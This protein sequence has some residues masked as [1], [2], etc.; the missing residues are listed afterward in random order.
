MKQ[1]TAWLLSLVL[2]FTMLCP[3][4]AEEEDEEGEEVS[5]ELLQESMELDAIDDDEVVYV[6]GPTYHEPDAGEFTTSSPAVYTAKTIN[7][8]IRTAS[9][10]A[11]VRGM[12][13]SSRRARGVTR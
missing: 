5:A 4:L 8:A 13:R 10:H 3:V 7:T 11:G 2:L 1:L 6:S 9:K 12:M